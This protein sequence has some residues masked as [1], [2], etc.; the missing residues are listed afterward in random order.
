[1]TH[2]VRFGLPEVSVPSLLDARPCCACS[3]ALRLAEVTA[4]ASRLK[5]VIPETTALWARTFHAVYGAWH[6]P[7]GWLAFWLVGLT[8]TRNLSTGVSGSENGH[9][10]VCVLTPVKLTRRLGTMQS[11]GAPI[12]REGL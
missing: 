11:A 7:A 12:S 9:F 1:M 8:R 10:L 6:F 4:A 3:G 5:P 2:M